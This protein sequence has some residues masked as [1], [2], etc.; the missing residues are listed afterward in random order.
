MGISR[1][2]RL[3]RKRTGGKRKKFRKKRKF[4]MGRPASNTRLGAKRVRGVR[5]RGGGL[6]WRALRLNSGNFV[7][8]T[9]CI[10]KQVRIVSVVYNACNFEFVRRNLLTKGT[11]VAIEKT[12]YEDQ[13]K[14]NWGAHPKDGEIYKIDLE[15]LKE[16]DENRKHT[17]GCTRRRRKKKDWACVDKNLKMVFSKKEEP[18]LA[19]IS[20]RA[21]QCGR[22]DG[23][24]LEG[25]ELE[26]YRR[27]IAERKKGSRK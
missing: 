27:K 2:G 3:K 5:T 18:L 1:E 4:G 21:G 14:L 24:I 26:F 7:W 13:Y 9:Q 19:V 11:V 15:M 16:L 22:A 6:K 23:Y 17:R 12:P 25:K 10:N 20:S 8:R